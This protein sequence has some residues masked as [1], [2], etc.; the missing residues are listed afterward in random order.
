MQLKP[1]LNTVI[2]QT[3]SLPGCTLDIAPYTIISPI[4]VSVIFGTIACYLSGRK[5]LKERAA[6]A[7]RPKLPKK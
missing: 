7:M 3:Y 6:Q 5:V 2:E 4:I 1:L